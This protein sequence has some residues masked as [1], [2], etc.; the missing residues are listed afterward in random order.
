M[1]VDRALGS[2]RVGAGTAF[3]PLVFKSF[4]KMVGVYPVGTFLELED[5]GLVLVSNPPLA[6]DLTRL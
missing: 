3:D 2:M 6:D 5:G 1:S 4:M